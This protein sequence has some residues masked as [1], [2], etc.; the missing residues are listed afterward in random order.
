M[1]VRVSR[2]LTNRWSQRLRARQYRA[3]PSRR[4]LSHPARQ[5]SLGY[6]ASAACLS[7]GVSY[8]LGA[9]WIFCLLEEYR[10]WSRPDVRSLVVFE[11]IGAGE[12]RVAG[13]RLRGEMNSFWAAGSFERACFAH[14]N[15]SLEPTPT[16]PS[17]SRSAVT[18]PA[19]AGVAPALARLPA[20]CG[21]PQLWR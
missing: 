7:S 1:S 11:I 17:V 8:A 19:A 18:P 21:V 2:M 4:L 5:L 3:P 10:I 9:P 16:R 20:G 12:T 6:P 14:A 13:V 15:K